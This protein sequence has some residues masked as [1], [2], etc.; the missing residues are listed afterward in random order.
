MNK[1]KRFPFCLHV[2]RSLSWEVVIGI[3]VGDKNPEFGGPLR[4]LGN[5]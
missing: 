1:A 3:E 2:A 4:T 5:Q